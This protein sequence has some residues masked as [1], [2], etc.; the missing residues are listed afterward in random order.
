[1]FHTWQVSSFF[2][3]PLLLYFLLSLLS[4]DL[5][6]SYPVLGIVHN[7]FLSA[8]PWIPYNCFDL[9]LPVYACTAAAKHCTLCFLLCECARL[10]EQARASVLE[11]SFGHLF[12]C[13]SF[14]R[15]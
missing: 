2:F 5:A 11:T 14:T 15:F 3:K 6:R 8:L 12:C 13:Q 10:V 9:Y 1:M 4:G 7:A